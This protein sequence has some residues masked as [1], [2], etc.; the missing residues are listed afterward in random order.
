MVRIHRREWL[1][2]TIIALTVVA[3]GGCASAEPDGPRI[4]QPGA[5]GEQ[6]RE[7]SLE[8]LQEIDY[9]QY[10]EA[11][12]EFMQGMMLHH[13]QALQMTRMV[14]ARSGREDIPLLARR[15]DLSQ[16]AEIEQMRQWLEE[17]GEPVP[18]LLAEH[19]HGDVTVPD[20]E[21]MPGMLTPEQLLELQRADGEDFDRRFLESMIFH[22]EGAVTMVEDL[23]GTEGGGTDIA[24]SVF[25]NHV[26]ADQT[27][28]IGRMQR[29][30]D[31]MAD[32]GEPATG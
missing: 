4:V 23:F 2:A 15:I 20:G 10:S 26:V 32:G 7:L 24:V 18:S 30:L 1:R 22:H 3:A 8:E 29:I 28:E 16:E 12:V 14:P 13:V 25:A 6:S 9:S 27:I 19:D 11:D 21:L 17:R 31:E 5:P